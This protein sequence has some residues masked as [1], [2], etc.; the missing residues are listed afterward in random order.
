MIDNI[1]NDN[2]FGD[3]RYLSNNQILKSKFKKKKDERKPVYK[4]IIKMKK[5]KVIQNKE[6]FYILINNFKIKI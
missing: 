2:K 4:P 5:N 3:T 1:Q 6:T